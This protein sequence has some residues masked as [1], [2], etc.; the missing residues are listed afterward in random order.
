MSDIIKEIA[1]L[2]P[3][4]RELIEG[5]LEKIERKEAF[6]LSEVAGRIVQL[7]PEQR[8]LVKS[9][10]RRA[11]SAANGGGGRPSPPRLVALPRGEGVNVFPVSFAQQ[12]LWLLD[13]IAPGDPAYNQPYAV[14]LKADMD[15]ATLEQAIAEVVR[16]HESLRTTFST[17]DG[18][19]VQVVSPSQTFKLTQRDLR[20]LSPQERRAEAL[21]LAAEDGRRPF[22]LKRGP[23]MRGMLLRVGEQEQLLVLTMHHIVFDGLSL[24]AMMR[25][26]GQLYV[27]CKLGL[28]SPLPELPIQYADF[29]V[30]Q[31]EWLGGETL[32]TH[33]A[34]WREQ[35]G[36]ELPVLKLPSFKPRP[37][38]PTSAG[39]TYPVRFSPEL[40][41][42]LR[43][44]S[45]RTDVSLVMTLLAAFDVLLYRYTGQEDVVV[46]SPIAGH[47][48]GE[49]EGLI[50]F[51]VNTLVLR[52]DLSGE[53]TFREL[54][55]RV[56][57]VCL[58]AYAHQEVPFERLVEEL[59]PER[60]EGR[61]PL[62]QVL[63]GLFN[64]Q[65]QLL[66]APGLSAE[67]IDVNIGTSKF[68]LSLYLYDEPEEVSGFIEYSTDLFDEA[69]VKRLAEHFDVLLRA[70]VADP[71]R[72]ISEVPLM[73]E[74]ERR[75][76]LEEWNRTAREYPKDRCV[77]QLFE[78]QAR[79]TP[80][81][82]AVAF[83]GR[84]LTYGELNRRANQLAHHLLAAGA[85]PGALVGL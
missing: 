18:Q 28:P 81:A 57:E 60:N 62:F 80:D 26:I 36:G 63:L 13:Q 47:T 75:R 64:P 59:H 5:L 40:T 27:A 41:K 85:G 22:D 66:Q 15:A 35:L 34:Y 8:E 2:P 82:P 20:G 46:G 37:E 52:T 33:L 70:V 61:T 24:I 16:R 19:P 11:M 3:E 44:L 65:R 71:D 84:E 1:D 9:V 67:V 31:R 77:H 83:E 53:P 7:P 4:P 25:E 39:A 54:L 78:E 14:L 79:R 32:E 29:A 58:G 50:G 43:E 30:W 74:A 17:V 73:T 42:A 6:Q 49:L 38:L 76:E 69:T 10:L 45:W 12:R 23:L 56:R 55:K 48:R 72:P 68:D 21:R 51:F